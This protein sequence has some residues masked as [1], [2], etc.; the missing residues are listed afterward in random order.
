MTKDAK[1][2]NN[3]ETHQIQDNNKRKVVLL[4]GMGLNGINAEGWFPPAETKDEAKEILEDGWKLLDS[5]DT[6]ILGRVTFQM[7]EKHWPRQANS[8]SDFSKRFSLFVDKIQKI[9]I[10]T[11]LKSVNWQNSKVIKEDIG[12]EISRIKK[13][14]GKN[15]AVVGGPRIAQTFIKLNLIDE[16]QLYLHQIIFG[17]GKSLLGTLDIDRQL[18][19]IDIKKFASG[20][21]RF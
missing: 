18:K 13:L 10:S 17:P 16:Y 15:I 21:L 14:P 8:S 1:K 5:I 6:F 3:D 19:L 7:W 11:T 4:M 2:S 12:T 20:G 9:V